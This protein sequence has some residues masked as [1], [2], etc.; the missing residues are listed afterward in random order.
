MHGFL[1][2]VFQHSLNS[3]DI[4]QVDSYR[5]LGILRNSKLSW[6]EHISKLVGDTS[7]SVGYL[8]KALALSPPAIRKIAHE[9]F[10]RSILEF[11]SPIWSAY[12]DRLI[13][14]VQSVQN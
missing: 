5:Y 8:K 14:S 11:A 3:K 6:F 4:Y 12:Q 10:I 7:R 9:T 13:T 2:L 1:T